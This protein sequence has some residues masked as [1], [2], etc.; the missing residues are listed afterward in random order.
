MKFQFT[1]NSLSPLLLHADDVEK[2]DMLKQWRSDPANK[3]IS[4]PGDDR[5]PPWTWQ[6]YLYTDGTHLTIPAD[7]LSPCLMQGAAQ[8]ILKK[9]KTFKEVSQTGLF[10]GED[11]FP[12]LINGKPIESAKI[13]AIANKTFA[14]QAQ[15]VKP[16][17]LTLF[18]KRAPVG[19]KSKHVRVRARADKWSITGTIE[20]LVPEITEERLNEMF[21]IAGFYKGL[22]DWRPGSKTPGRFGRF[23]HTLTK[24]SS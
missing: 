4:V 16:L 11:H 21:R 18:V 24:L 6:T 3:N 9:Q 20:I 7:N 10:I 22:C 15:A 23:E 12:I 8:M 1:L 2:A 17:G 13:D 5:S 14:E 19:G